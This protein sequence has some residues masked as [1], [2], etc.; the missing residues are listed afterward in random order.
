VRLIVALAP[1]FVLWEVQR[2]PFTVFLAVHFEPTQTFFETHFV[3]S[4]VL[5][6]TY[7]P[8]RYVRL[9][10]PRFLRLTVTVCALAE[11]EELS[12]DKVPATNAT[13]NIII[14]AKKRAFNLFIFILLIVSSNTTRKSL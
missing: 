4:H 2:V 9:A 12:V 11:K 13:D 14:E 10:T 7:L 8:P 3:P 1:R 6:T 5:R